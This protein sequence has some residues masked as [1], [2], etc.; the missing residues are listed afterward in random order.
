MSQEKV[1]HPSHYQGEGGM[2]AIDAIIGLYGRER[3]A[4]WC[5]ITAFK[6]LTR[7]GKKDDCIQEA[8]KAIWYLTKY[9]EL[10]TNA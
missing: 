9:K 2:E 7:M 10:K 1:N 8:D 5:H 3:A 4:D 6:Y